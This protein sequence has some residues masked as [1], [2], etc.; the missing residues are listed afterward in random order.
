MR[1]WDAIAECRWLG[2]D[3]AENDRA[4]LLPGIDR[5]V[6]EHLKLGIG[7]SFTD[8]SDELTDLD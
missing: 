1:K 2:V 3:E 6:G 4:G 7:Y 8:F 5:Q